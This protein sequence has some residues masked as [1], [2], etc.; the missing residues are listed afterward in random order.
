MSTAMP[1]VIRWGRE[2]ARASLWRGQAS[3]ACLTPLPDAP[4]PSTA[5]VRRCID[6]LTA[7]GFSRVVTSALAPAEQQGFLRAGFSVE[8]RLHLLG[9]DLA[10]LPAANATSLRRGRR[11]D[12]QGVLE[13]DA[14]AFPPFWRIDE[15]GLDE[16]VHATGSARFRVVDGP[17]GV[18]A[19]AITGRAG[20]RGFLQR[21]AVAPSGQRQGQGRALVVDALRW[22]RR[23]RVERAMVN[24]QLGNDAAVA[25]Y[26]SVGFTHEAGGLCV[27]SLD[28]RP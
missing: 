9:H 25:L 26:E 1:G 22:L 12:R 11:A 27:L 28:L 6:Q 15:A 17:S 8:E 14:A 3:V 13:V 7:E 23:W 4:L 2:R 21:L 20:R 5:F 10:G 18:T 24:T 19:Y 16:A